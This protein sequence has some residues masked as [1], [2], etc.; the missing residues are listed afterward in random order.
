MNKLETR[1]GLN[2]EMVWSVIAP[3]IILCAEKKGKQG[4]KEQDSFQNFS[5]Y[6]SGVNSLSRCLRG[7]LCRPSAGPTPDI[8]H[9]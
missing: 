3:T 7:A 2:L 8:A 6:S 4:L 5:S 1:D 9:S